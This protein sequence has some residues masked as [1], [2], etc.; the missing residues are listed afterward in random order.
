[1]EYSPHQEIPGHILVVVNTHHHARISVPACLLPPLFPGPSSP[2]AL[3][4]PHFPL[5][6]WLHQ[7]LCLYMVSPFTSTYKDT[8]P[9]FWELIF[10]NP[11]SAFHLFFPNDPSSLSPYRII[12]ATTTRT[13]SHHQLPLHNT[14]ILSP[15]I[16]TSNFLVDN[17]IVFCNCQLY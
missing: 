10:L 14:H 16:G 6:N 5:W 15:S 17:P 2:T 13:V 1:M 4:R 12:S 8:F 7:L 9:H 11:N 3:S